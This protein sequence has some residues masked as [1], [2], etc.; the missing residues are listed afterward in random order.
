MDIAVLLLDLAV[1]LGTIVVL[2]TFA[3]GAL[4][5][6]PW[7]P[8]RRADVGR[9]V[10]LAGVKPGM[11]VADVGC[12]DG[13]VLAALAVTGCRIRGWELAIVPWL[14]AR[15][16]FRHHADARIRFGDFWY[17]NL[18]D[19]DLV[20]AFLLPNSHAKLAVKL[21]RELRPGARVI[22][23][24]WPF[25]GWEPIAVDRADGRAPLYLYERKAVEA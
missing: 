12:G 3:W 22:A 17:A 10:A 20:Y 23:H 21:A 7:L 11:V 16:R 9:I 24:V 8:T 18:S 1:V 25:P 4:R 2:G 6:A 5:G 13:G 14:R 15:W 19:C